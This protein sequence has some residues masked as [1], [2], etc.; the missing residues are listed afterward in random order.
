MQI[1]STIHSQVCKYLN[2]QYPKVLFCTDLS[3]IKLT[4]GQAKKIKSLRSNRSWPDI[5]LAEPRSCYHGLYLE[6]K[7]DDVKI[8]LIN[9]QMTADKHIRE[10]YNMLCQLEQRGYMARFACGF[11]QAR[12]IIDEYLAL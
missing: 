5:Y 4:I 11:N 8:I 7:A 9:G 1:E 3:G 2:Y 10:Q 6:L 12:Q